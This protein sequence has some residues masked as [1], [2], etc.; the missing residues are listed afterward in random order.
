MLSPRLLDSNT[1]NTLLSLNSSNIN[2]GILNVYQ[3]GTGSTSLSFG[4]V[5]IGNGSSSLIQS[6][7]LTW[8]NG[9]N[10]LSASNFIGS[11]TGLTN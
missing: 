1:I 8:N 9:N 11:G 4:Q 7:N 10:T 3:G 2:S 6:A 5:L